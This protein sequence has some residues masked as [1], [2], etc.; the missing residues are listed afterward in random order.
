MQP[1]QLVAAVGGKGSGRRAK[2][3][4]RKRRLGNLGKR[5]LPSIDGNVIALPVH[6]IPEPHRK[7]AENYGLRLWNAVWTAGASW[8]KPSMDAE[9]VLM[10]CE[11]IDERVMLRNTVMLNPNQ[12]RERR[13]LRE[14]DKQ[15]ASL[16][17][18]LG[19]S[20]TERAQLG[21]SNEQ[22]NEFAA[23]R[24]RIDAKRNAAQQ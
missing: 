12:W 16:L 9:V 6:S 1:A 2:P 5:T 13:A 17:G 23:I 21:V 24:A 8:L 20:P 11:A 18:Q 10:A 7:L 19:F 3:V 22:R 15:I 14:L 4:E